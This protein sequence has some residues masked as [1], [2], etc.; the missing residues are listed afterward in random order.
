MCGLEEPVLVC[1]KK[2]PSVRC[3]AQCA[4][5]NGVYF[6]VAEGTPLG[7]C[8]IK[9]YTKLKEA[10]FVLGASSR[11]SLFGPEHRALRALGAPTYEVLDRV[12]PAPSA[13]SRTSC[14]AARPHASCRMACPPARLPTLHPR[15]ISYD[16]IRNLP[17]VELS[18]QPLPASPPLPDSRA[19]HGTAHRSSLSNNFTSPPFL[20]PHQWHS[21]SCLFGGP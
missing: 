11:R 17:C 20:K 10:C 21:R 8:T 6:P 2:A 14:P 12:R 13:P 4:D 5:E 16:R 18:G 9:T 7:T 1:A 19:V 15:P 3:D